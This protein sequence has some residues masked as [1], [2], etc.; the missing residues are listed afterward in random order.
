LEQT[1]D[2]TSR[3]SNFKTS[4]A[5]THDSALKGN[6]GQQLGDMKLLMTRSMSMSLAGDQARAFC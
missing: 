6:S 2:Y 3:I 1:H 4:T 5:K